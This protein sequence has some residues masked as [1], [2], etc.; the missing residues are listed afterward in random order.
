MERD[1]ENYN[2]E[3]FADTDEYRK[4]NGDIIRDWI[5]I[6]VE[7]GVQSLDKFLDIATGAGTMAQ[8]FFTMLPV[9]L[10]ESAV[11]CLD[12]ST[13]ALKFAKSRLE[14]EIDKLTLINSSIQDLNLPPKSLDVAIWGNGIHYLNEEDQVR[15]LESIRKVLKSGG[16]FFF[17][18]S[19]Y[20]EARPQETLPFYRTQVKNAVQFLKKQ[21][22][23]RVKE[24]QKAEAA[25]FHPRSYYEDLVKKSGFD[26][27]EVREFA[28][29]LTKEAW[30]H[31]S[32]FQQYAAGA[33]HGYP[34]AVASTA[35]R[36]AVG[37]A[38][39]LHGEVNEEGD[40]FVTRNWLSI[41]ART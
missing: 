16:W 25:K 32:G 28:A 21:G 33:L 37:P 23:R 27:V 19:F 20:E 7:R 38:I 6:M 12:Q 41:S 4:V 40:Y 15:S 39:V 11:C 30:E 31:I 36:D 18:T 26:L 17:N 29:D 35:M 34:E 3:P 1:A 9:N 13:G 24:E 8:L 2:Y 10:K 22:V 14:R 5:R